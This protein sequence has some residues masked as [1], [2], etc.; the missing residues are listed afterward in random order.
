MLS[1]ISG[2]YLVGLHVRYRFF[3]LSRAISCLQRSG[4]FRPCNLDT[5]LTSLS[6]IGWRDL[7]FLHIIIHIIR[8]SSTSMVHTRLPTCAPIRICSAM[9]VIFPPLNLY[10]EWMASKRNLNSCA[11]NTAC[12]R[13]WTQKKTEAFLQFGICRLLRI[14]FLCTRGEVQ[15]GNEAILNIVFGHMYSSTAINASWN[16]AY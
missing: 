12:T 1:V 11:L 9:W 3:F 14:Q 10:E 13:V 7:P 6:N 16:A 5:D 2:L 8:W 4:E 15:I